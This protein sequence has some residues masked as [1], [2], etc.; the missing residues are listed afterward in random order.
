MQAMRRDPACA[1]EARDA[2]LDERDPGL[3]AVLTFEIP[4]DEGRARG[5]R[6]KRPQVAGLREQGVNGQRE[7]AA[8]LDRA[9]FDAF[10]VHMNDLIDGRVDLGRFR[11]IVA[12]GGF[13]YGDVLGAGEGWAKSILHIPRLRDAFTEYFLRQDT[14]ALGVCN[15]WQMLAGLRS[16]I[17]GTECWP[18]F[19]RKRSAHVEG[20]L[21]LR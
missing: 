17:P 10:D 13:S 14:F 9:G 8:T 5:A 7:M 11:G 4:V 15:G 12:G 6:G 16:V 19:G 1:R 18:R 20:A 21:A 3:N 2:T